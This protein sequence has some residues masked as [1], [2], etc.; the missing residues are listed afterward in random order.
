M[1][2]AKILR[3]TVPG[4]E[5]AWKSFRGV[6][7][8]TGIDVRDF[9]Q[10]NYR[11]YTDGPEFLADP[12]D[13]TQRLW[14]KVFDLTREELKKGGLLE[15]DTETIGGI[16]AHG[17]GYIDKDLEVIVG[18]QTDKPLKRATMP[19]G[20]IRMV[21][22]SYK[23]YG[24]EVPREIKKIFSE[25]RKTHNQG[26]FN[27]YTDEMLRARKVGIITGLPDAYGRGRIIG[28][29]RRAALYGVDRLIQSRQEDRLKLEAGVMYEEAIRLREETAEQVQALEELKRMALSYGFDVSGPAVNAQ[30]A[31][32]WVYFAYLGAVKEQN[33]AAM[34]LG[35]VSTFLDIYIQRDLDQGLIT[36]EQAQELIDQLVVKLRMVRFLRTP[37]Y[38]ELFSGDPTW[39][40]EAIG[41]MGVDGRTLVTKTAFRFLHTLTNLGSAPEPNMTVLWA[42][43][44]PEPFK[45]YCAELSIQTC[46][47]Q[48][49]ND[50]LMRPM[51]GDD[52]AIACCVS[53]MRV[54][55]QMQFFG[56]RANLAKALLYAINGGWDEKRGIQVG[57]K[58]AP[59]T[60]EYLDYDE[61]MDRFEVVT[62]WLA[63]LY[64]NTLNIIH[65][66][67]DRY[68]YER[69]QFALHDVNIYR[70][71]VLPG[72]RWWPIP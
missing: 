43:R 13:R 69:L 26:V 31:V 41:G 40:T 45:K 37:E 5:G 52:Y 61:V 56:A 60:S 47:I 22:S 57:P 63:R 58:F 67:H 44:L 8:Q 7:W 42:A 34:S 19:F 4:S 59:I 9:I 28:D 21:E 11:P 27:A 16:A 17:P 65:Y 55:K 68:Y 64:I 33:G 38:D 12:T 71:A 23:A 35:R 14:A 48:Y 6:K 66:M 1:E 39:V 24:H 29:Y 10:R 30:E 15:L 2:A 25:Y 18:L 54:G 36:E 72:F 46:S 32:Q 70:T 62:E 51:W 53:A 49:E 50:D 20:G 3:D